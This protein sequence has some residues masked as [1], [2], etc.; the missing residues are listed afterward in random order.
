MQMDDMWARALPLCAPA[1]QPLCTVRHFDNARWKERGEEAFRTS[2]NSYPG[3]VP[4][5]GKAHAWIKMHLVMRRTC[6]ACQLNRAASNKIHTCNNKDSLWAALWNWSDTCLLSW[7]C[8]S[9][10]FL[11]LLGPCLPCAIQHLCLPMPTKPLFPYILPFLIH[12]LS[13]FLL[14]FLSLG[15]L[16]FTCFL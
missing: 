3:T 7:C 15:L 12:H 10:S 9:T 1:S 8:T 4:V 13:I 2:N 11:N 6:V 16:T 14:A 5:I